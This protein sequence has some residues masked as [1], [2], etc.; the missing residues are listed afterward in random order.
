MGSKY[1][2]QA[3]AGYNSSPPSDNGSQT[4]S[5][6]ITWAGIKSKLADVLKTF[7]E[8][9]NTALVSAFDYSV[10]AITTSDSTVA[11]D[12]MR[13]VEI[14][15][16]V[17]TAVTVALGDAST[18]TNVYRVFV[19]NSSAINQTVSRVTGGDTVDGAAANVILPPGAG[20]IFQTNN[21][22]NGYITNSW[23]GPI[24]DGNPIVAGGTD[25]TKK[26]RLEVD[27]LTTATTRVITVPDASF[28][29]PAGAANAATTLAG[30]DATQFLTSAGMAGNKDI[31]GNAGF[32]KLPGGLILQWDEVTTNASGVVTWTYPTAFASQCFF[33][34]GSDIA[35]DADRVINFATP[36]ASTV[37]IAMLDGGVQTTTTMKVFAVGI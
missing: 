25:G 32:Y 7:G 27:G 9:I 10:R 17:T 30:S 2:T 16:T 33:V 20:A 37:A 28:T 23:F 8:A 26:V 18:M 14:A 4:A 19:K 34:A 13:C 24:S 1:T 36:G 3:S 15:S 21:G 5:N 22:A 6:L 35:N 11:G 12:H 29:L 31:V